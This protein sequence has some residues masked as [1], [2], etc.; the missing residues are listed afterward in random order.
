MKTSEAGKVLYTL[1]AAFPNSYKNMEN[2]LSKSIVELWAASFDD[3]PFQQ[4]Y[5]AVLGWISTEDRGFPPSVGQI[6]NML[7]KLNGPKELTEGEAWG[8]VRKALKNSLYSSVDEFNALP[9]VVRYAVGSPEMLKSWAQV[10]LDEL[11]TVIQSNFMRTFRA[12]SAN[13]K[14]IKLLP[15]AVREKMDQVMLEGQEQAKFD[16]VQVIPLQRPSIKEP[17][18]IDCIGDYVKKRA[19]ELHETH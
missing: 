5:D 18:V 12:K 2:G 6:K 17:Q 19:G 15:Q 3:I 8:T 9:E 7:S 14:E 4:V 13:I 10:P 11:E 1:K 16:C